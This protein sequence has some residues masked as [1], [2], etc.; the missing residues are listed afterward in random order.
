MMIHVSFNSAQPDKSSRIVF[1]CSL[2]DQKIKELAQV[3]HVMG[4][5][6]LRDTSLLASLNIAQEVVI[7]QLGKLREAGGF[8]PADKISC[9]ANDRRHR[10]RAI[11][12]QGQPLAELRIIQDH[13]WKIEGFVH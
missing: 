8:C 3:S 6:L 12:P 4:N 13:G 5:R 11:A 7:A 10:C 1:A 9:L 2:A